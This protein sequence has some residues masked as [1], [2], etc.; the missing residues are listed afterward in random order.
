MLP[1]LL[2]ISMKEIKA[3]NFGA[4]LKLRGVGWFV[5]A[6]LLVHDYVMLAKGARKL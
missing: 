3:E 1:C 5:M 2:N 6:C 4:R